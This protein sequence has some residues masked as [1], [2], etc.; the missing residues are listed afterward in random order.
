MGKENFFENTFLYFYT[1]IHQFIKIMDQLLILI[2][3][4]SLLTARALSRIVIITNIS[5]ITGGPE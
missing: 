1:S 2:K 5:K 3:M 4:Q